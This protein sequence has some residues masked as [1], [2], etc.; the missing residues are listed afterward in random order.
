MLGVIII[1][2]ELGWRFMYALGWLCVVERWGSARGYR[3][4]MLIVALVRGFVRDW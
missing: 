1:C 4:T 2:S 3:G